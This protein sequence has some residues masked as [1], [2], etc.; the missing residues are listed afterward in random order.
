ML[1]STQVM[2]NTL[3]Y[4]CAIDTLSAGAEVTLQRDAAGK[5]TGAGT[6]I[7]LQVGNDHQ[8]VPFSRPHKK[9]TVTNR[10]LLC[11]DWCITTRAHPRVC[12]LVYF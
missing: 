9:I 8:A 3:H 5:I 1:A 12:T 7:K 4:Y 11:A 10:A 6:D 2:I